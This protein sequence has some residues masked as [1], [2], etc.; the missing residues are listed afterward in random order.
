M[1]PAVSDV[2]GV[3]NRFQV[4]VGLHQIKLMQSQ[5]SGIPDCLMCD[6]Y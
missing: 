4:E 6:R 1:R 3:T 2:V 5:S